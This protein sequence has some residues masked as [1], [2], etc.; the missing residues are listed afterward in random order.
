VIRIVPYTGNRR[1]SF[2]ITERAVIQTAQTSRNSTD[3]V[4]EPGDSGG[5]TETPPPSSD[6]PSATVNLVSLEQG[7][8]ALAIGETA[9][10]ASQFSG[11]SLPLV[12][13]SAPPEG[14]D[15]CIEIFGASG[16]SDTW[17]GHKGGTVIVKSP[18]GGGHVLVTAFGLPA[19]IVPVP[20]IDVRRLDLPPS[21]YIYQSL[22]MASDI[23][24]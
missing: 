4:A 20:D 10:L 6:V 17:V 24:P 22:N 5:S 14:G 21:S 19:Q 11:L 13:V 16:C 15:R 2:P 12:H 8:Y 9:C 7:L 23:F 3:C 18:P 1:V